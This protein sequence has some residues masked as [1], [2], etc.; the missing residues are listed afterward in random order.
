MY[1][2]RAVSSCV[3]GISLCMALVAVV[4]GVSSVSGVNVSGFP[5]I[6]GVSSVGCD[7]MY[8]QVQVLTWL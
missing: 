6:S 1:S 5:A 7:P 8:V 2:S 3:L 4:P